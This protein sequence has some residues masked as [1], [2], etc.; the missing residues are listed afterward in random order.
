M[1]DF[2]LKGL[3]EK[4]GYT[5]AELASALQCGQDY[6]SRMESNPGNMSLEFFAV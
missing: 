6:I 2:D 3:R 5:Q 4:L 1:K